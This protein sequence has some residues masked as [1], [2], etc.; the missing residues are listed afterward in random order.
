MAIPNHTEPA[1]AANST[2]YKSNI[3][4]TAQDHEDRIVDAENNISD[5]QDSISNI[6]LRPVFLDAR[7]LLFSIAQATPVNWTTL[8]M[9]SLFN[10]A[11]SDGAKSA[12]L[13]LQH[14][15]V[16]INSSITFLE[17]SSRLHLAREGMSGAP[18]SSNDNFVRSLVTI[19][20]YTTTAQTVIESSL[21]EVSLPLDGSSNFQYA[22]TIDVTAGANLGFN[23]KGYLIGYDF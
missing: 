20:K 5:I 2:L 1:Q 15:I 19:S 10:Q 22:H 3:D 6:P 11:V 16:S 14:Q 13:V 18:S 8:D 4:A 9:S 7:F 21:N 23:L 17:D 12:K